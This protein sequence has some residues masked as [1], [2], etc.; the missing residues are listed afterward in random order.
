MA[1]GCRMG[2]GGSDGWMTARRPETLKPTP[3]GPTRTR[4]PGACFA[5]R[6]PPRS[7]PPPV[8]TIV[9]RYGAGGRVVGSR[10]AARLGVLFLDRV[11]DTS[12]AERAHV[13]SEA[14]HAHT[15]EAKAGLSRLLDQLAVVT[16][17]DLSTQQPLEDDRRLQVEV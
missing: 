9:A 4:R 5:D 2:L 15:E 13:P 1:L 12:V 11:I 3:S 8:V 7:V 10:V 17:P 14:V 16:N 6:C